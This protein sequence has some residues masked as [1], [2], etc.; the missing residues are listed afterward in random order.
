M[1]WGRTLLIVFTVLAVGV[2]CFALGLSYGN[3]AARGEA[4]ALLKLERDRVEALEAELTKTRA[5]LDSSRAELAAL[6]S[7]LEETKRLLSQAER[8]ALDIQISV[9]RDLQELRARSDDLSRRASE[10]ESRLQSI[11]RQVVTVSKAIPLL[12][13]LRGVNQL[14][15]DRNATLEYWLDVK[16]LAA[17]FDPALTPSVD[18]IINN[19]DGL[20]DYYEWLDQ[21][22]GEGATGEQILQWFQSFPPSYTQY[23][24]SVNQ[25]VN[26]VLTSVTSKLTALRD[27]LG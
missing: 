15:P 19:V 13:Q 8:R 24:E 23:V 2:A 3:L 9:E 20:M 12:N 18:R 5:E 21:F 4:E 1:Q 27:S 25:F 14:G 11:S 16:S 10:A 22:P 6:Q 26:E 17:S 7:T